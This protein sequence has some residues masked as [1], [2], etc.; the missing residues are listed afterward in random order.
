MFKPYYIIKYTQITFRQFILYSTD[1]HHLEFSIY[2]NIIS[3]EYYRSY[4]GKRSLNTFSYYMIC[5]Q[6]IIVIVDITYGLRVIYF[7]Q[8]VDISVILL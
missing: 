7:E 4:I 1:N 5:N 6:F 8:N 3:Y 2:N